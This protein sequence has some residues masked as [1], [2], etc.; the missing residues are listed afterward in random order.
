MNRA[1]ENEFDVGAV[2]QLLERTSTTSGRKLI[3]LLET[4]SVLLVFLRHAGCTFCRESLDDIAASRAAIEARGV[5]I[6][7]VH[8]D[9]GPAMEQMTA[10]Y[11]VSD[12]DRIR[13][14]RQELYQAFGLQRG[15]LWQLFGPKVIW[16][17][18]MAGVVHGH[19]VGKP[20]AD[21]M[22]MPGVFLIEQGMIVSHYR[23]QTAA[24][25]PAYKEMC[26][27]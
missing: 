26:E 17:G 24:D 19:G 2:V 22:Q 12:L 9:D 21:P 7:L 10:R 5:R 11:Q 4:N 27:R 14:S 3:D 18:F 13:D 20:A 16:R 1:A 25:R 23:H 6:V 8:L 15:S